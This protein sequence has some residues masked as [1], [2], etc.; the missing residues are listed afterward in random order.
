MKQNF[1]TLV[2][3][4]LLPAAGSG[5]IVVPVG[6]L[7]RGPALTEQVLVQGGGFFSEEKIAIID[8]DGMISGEE[9][10]SP[11]L[12]QENTLSETKA[13]LNF[14]RRDPDVRAVVLRISSPGGEVTACDVLHHEV[15]R[16]KQERKIPVVASIGDQG[17]SGGYYL[18]VA[19]DKIYA[20]PT[21]IVGSIGVLLQ[22]MDLSGLLGK[23]GVA[24]HPLKSSEKKDISSPFRPMSAEE[25]QILQRLVD[26]MYNR[27]IDVVDDGRP[28]LNREQV[29]GLA[30]GRV[31]SGI[32]A[33]KLGLIDRAAYLSDV[34][35]DVRKEA[36]IAQ[37]TIVRY[38]RSPKSGANIF[39]ESS[40]RGPLASQELSLSLRASFDG[41]PRLYYL[42]RP[43][44]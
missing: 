39:T 29:K 4:V 30:D 11:L 3:A 12:P 27:F 35:D 33:E 41:A 17:T 7:L 14:A 25:E 21:A 32:E 40:T 15:Q 9:G 22:H 2:L 19:A 31:V 37:P 26:D 23:I 13:R 6:E 34:L 44:Q 36:G 18:A 8:V 43:G 16:F 28:G 42:W 38:T 24:F 5:C 1:L 10:D 20:N